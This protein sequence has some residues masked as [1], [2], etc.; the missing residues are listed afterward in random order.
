MF[1]STAL[2]L[3]VFA[4]LC[5]CTIFSSCKREKKAE[6]DVNIHRYEVAL[7]E[8]NPDS[9]YALLPELSKEF[10]LYLQG[11]DISDTLNV[12]V[13]QSFMTEPLIKTLYEGIKEYYG[14]AEELKKELG[15]MFSIAK[16]IK[17]DF[18]TPE[19]YTYISGFDYP[20]RVVYSDSALSLSLD[21]YLPGRSE[22]YSKYGFPIYIS[23]RLSPEALLVDVARAIA[24]SLLPERNGVGSLLE[25][26]VY[27]GKVLCI[28]DRLL[29]KIDEKTKLAYTESQL[30]WCKA[31]ESELWKYWINGQLLYEKD[32]NLT[33]N[34][35]NDGPGNIIFD[36][37]PP[38]V[39]QYIGWRMV[40]EYIRK[41]SDFG[42]GLW[43]K[44]AQEVLS[45]SGYKP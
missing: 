39:V 10:P 25:E 17:P 12:L 34:F 26:I 27:N 35:I 1:K 21:M 15:S 31:N 13:L 43:N 45:V 23:E 8:S 41:T 19:V 24:F 32:I 18:R 40:S 16:T 44:P 33:R 28:V 6:V 11:A 7:M 3:C 29:P 30:K 22:L 2:A 37:A 14:N 9:I 38:R 4:V 20:N 42:S 5:C 36:G